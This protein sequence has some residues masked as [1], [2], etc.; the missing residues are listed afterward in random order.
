MKVVTLER[1]MRV[2]MNEYHDQRQAFS[3]H[4]S[5][6]C[7]E[8]NQSN[9]ADMTIYDRGAVL[10]PVVVYFAFRTHLGLPG[11]C[12]GGA[13]LERRQLFRRRGETPFQER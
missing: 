5:I 13:G 6:K 11:F 9:I 8:R 12:G 7:S 3:A 4:K 10:I 1:A 2:I